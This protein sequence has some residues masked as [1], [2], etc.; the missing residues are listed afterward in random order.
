M[1]RLLLGFSSKSLRCDSRRVRMFLDMLLAILSV[2][3][4]RADLSSK[5][6]Q[7]A[8][9]KGEG[10]TMGRDEMQLTEIWVA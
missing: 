6:M 9:R 8:E 1:N 10:V 7:D 5:S 2:Q 4:F 3:N